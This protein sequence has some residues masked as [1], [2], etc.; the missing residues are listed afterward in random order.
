MARFCSAFGSKNRAKNELNCVYLCAK[1]LQLHLHY[2]KK[3]KNSRKFRHR[4]QLPTVKSMLSKFTSDNLIEEGKR[5]Y[6]FAPT[7][8]LFHD[9]YMD[10]YFQ[11]EISERTIQEN[12]NF[13]LLSIL[14]RNLNLFTEEESVCLEKLQQTFRIN[15]LHFAVKTYF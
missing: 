10:D 12:F 7:D 15:T 13:G 2:A 4:N 6:S 14:H 8:G 1:I 11:K 3:G 9:I 5:K